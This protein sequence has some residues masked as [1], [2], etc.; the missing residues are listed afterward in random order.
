MRTRRRE[1]KTK[2]ML[3]VSA[4]PQKTNCSPSLFVGAS[5]RERAETISSASARRPP[6]HP[7]VKLVSEN[8]CPA[9]HFLLLDVL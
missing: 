8:S 5:V 9:R 7:S 1:D 4:A 6:H 2:T 3:P